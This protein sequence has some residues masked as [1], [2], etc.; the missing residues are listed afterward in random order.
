M[1]NMCI[2]FT[3][4]RKK[5]LLLLSTA[6]F[7]ITSKR[8]WFESVM[9]LKESSFYQ[10][11]QHSHPL[12]RS[13]SWPILFIKYL[14]PSSCLFKDVFDPFLVWI[15]YTTVKLT[16]CNHFMH[17]CYCHDLIIFFLKKKKTF[18]SPCSFLNLQLG[19][20]CSQQQ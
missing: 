5:D 9:D 15:I 17:F 19:N 2:W 18:P 14:I 12:I 13:S 3:K 1:F 8:R 4:V 11:D 7:I 20:S 16:R 10:F 6:H